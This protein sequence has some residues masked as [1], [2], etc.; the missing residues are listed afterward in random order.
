MQ[1]R[2]ASKSKSLL[3]LQKAKKYVKITKLEGP[4]QKR[5]D[6]QLWLQPCELVFKKESDDSNS[7][8][9]TQFLTDC[10][11][12]QQKLFLMNAFL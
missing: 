8:S 5:L 11:V 2:K 1:M 3:I 12:K 7:T 4:P 10:I 9:T 6:D